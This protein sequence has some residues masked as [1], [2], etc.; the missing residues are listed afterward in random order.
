MTCED[1]I[2]EP[3]CILR[4]SYS[5]GDDDIT[6]EASTNMEELCR[7]F[8]NKADYVEVVRC[9]DCKYFREFSDAHKRAV[10]RADG[11]CFLKLTHSCDEQFIACRYNDFCSYGEQ[12]VNY[13]SS[14]TD[15]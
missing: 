7:S 2:F 1:C 3:Q 9:N 11:D 10:E 13:K 8:K 14:K 15:R 6:G 12:A 5:M 4:I